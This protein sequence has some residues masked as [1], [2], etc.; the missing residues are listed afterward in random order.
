MMA[1]VRWGHGD[2]AVLCALLIVFPRGAPAADNLDG[3]ARELAWK[4][5]SFA[6]KGEPVALTWRNQS[7]LA[8][9]E[10]GRARA[11]FEAAFREAGGAFGETAP[12]VEVRL[13]VSEDGTDYLLVEEARKGDQRL[14]WLAAW[15]R[16]DALPAAALTA[17]LDKKLVWERDEQILDAAFPG[18]FMLVLSPWRIA[19]FARQDGRWAQSATVALPVPKTWPR[20]PRGRLRVNGPRFQAYL[21]GGVACSGAWQPPVSVDCQ[22]SGE[23]W[24]LESGSRALLLANFAE[25]RNYFDGR[26]VTQTGAR[27][28]APPFYSAAAVEQHGQSL[29]LLALADGRARLFDASFQPAG[30]VDSWGSDIAGVDVRCG[31]GSGVLATRPGDGA[32][33]DAIQGFSIANGAAAALTPP[34]ELPGPV[35]ALWASGGASALA[36]SK[37]SSTGKYAAYLLTVACGQ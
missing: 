19:W 24:V 29:W 26:V 5:A 21:A 2:L 3:A 17:T 1:P 12:A 15:K 14:V 32:E 37:N 16:A 28:S 33:A 10:A 36:V 8:S 31:G 22:P 35:T 9:A 27:H 6:G 20:D 25:G 13:T 23:P 34:V 30:E 4:T 11:V 7:S 18:D